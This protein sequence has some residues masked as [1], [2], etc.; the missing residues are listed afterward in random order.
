MANEVQTIGGRKIRKDARDKVSG[1]AEYAA[2]IAVSNL[3]FGALVRSTHHFARI[4]NIDCSAAR[5]LPDVQTVITADD[6]PGSNIYG[7]LIQDQQVLARDFVRHIG[8]SIALVIARSESAA[9]KACESVVVEYECLE[10]VFDVQTALKEDAQN[11]H[12][13]GNLATHY[14]I[15][16]G[17]V[18]RGFTESDIVLEETFTV[19]RISPGY[20]EPE[21]S[22]ACWNSENKSVT[23]WVSSQHPYLD[24]KFISL[25]LDMPIEKVQV[26]SAV[27][28]GAFG[29]REDSCLAIL[30]ALGAYVIRG[31][32]RI[33]N[34]RQESFL[35]H[36][37]R[38]PARLTL[39]VGARSDGMLLALDGIGFL[40]TGAYASYGPAVGAIFSET[41]PGPYRI[42][43]VHVDTKVVYT[44]SPLSAAMRGF[45]SPQS[46]FAIESMMDMLAARL[47]L[48]PIEIRRKNILHPGDSLFTRVVMDDS[49]KCLEICLDTLEEVRRRYQEHEKTPGK[50]SGIGFA[51]AIQSMGLGAKVP[52]DSTQSLEWLPD[53]KVKIY[54]GA[55]DLGQGLA[56]ASEQITAEVLGLPYEDIS[57][58]ILDTWN[59]PNGGTTCASRMTYLVG[60]SL[61]AAAEK[62]KLRVIHEA[63]EL[64]N[65]SPNDLDYE[66][67]EIIRQDGQR[68]PVTEI[69]TRAAEK[70]IR[71]FEEASASF[72]YPEAT[73]PQHLPVGMPHVMFCFG[74]Q[75]ARVEVDE[76]LGT[77][78]VKDLYAIHDVGRVINRIGVEGQIEGGVSIGIG[79]ALYEN[80]SLKEG[81]Q[82]VDSFTEYLLPTIKDMPVNFDYKILE[83]PETSGPFGAKGVGEITL[84]PT[85]PAIANAVFDAVG[86]R[87][88]DLPIK[89]ETLIKGLVNV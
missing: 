4:K 6:I 48:D 22:V 61:V 3:S 19:P 21:N 89:P 51:L 23:V 78:E 53:G 55:P 41:I 37:K 36:P 45:G 77:V 9:R 28:G 47:Q 25:I 50:A 56:A 59:T 86:V 85:A 70:G 13:K 33:I 80:M 1:L 44:N 65:V 24:Q 5:M 15:E 17:D 18:E 87:V 39:K 69:I 73:T 31:A 43:N 66:A 54:L 88:F 68:L 40:D 67:G 16:N 81:K 34:N 27:I 11:I 79:Y 10:P 7:P 74:A 58:S 20:M 35:A 72:P 12:E 71:I 75:I 26:K 76:E 60:N 29:G 42:P 30:A 8:E 57:S 2:D 83:I 52:D 62:L 32:V 64:L 84:V 63:A 14:D 38:H 49:A 82:W 46:H